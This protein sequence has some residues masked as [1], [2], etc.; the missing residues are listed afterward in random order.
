M[1]VGIKFCVF[2]PKHQT[3]IPTKNSHLKVSIYNV[4]C[5]VFLSHRW[6]RL[7]VVKYLIEA[8]GCSAGCT[9]K[10]GRTPLHRACG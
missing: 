7:E 6:G 1:L 2:G 8:Q 9:D 4:T 5:L 10:K 3:L